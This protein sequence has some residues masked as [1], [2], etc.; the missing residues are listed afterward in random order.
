MT[1]NQ[2]LFM[3]ILIIALLINIIFNALLIPIYGINGAA[4]ALLLSML[5]WT[6]A[7]LVILKKKDIV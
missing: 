3:K 4:I 7:S 1:D 5:F 2:H 6:I